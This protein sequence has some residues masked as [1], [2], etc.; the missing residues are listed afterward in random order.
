MSEI[1]S[2]RQAK[3]KLI[4]A[5]YLYYAFRVQLKI[6]Y[7]IILKVTLIYLILNLIYLNFVNNLSRFP[8]MSK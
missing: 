3:L 2:T 4:I 5:F 7:C 1:M 8:K 6:I